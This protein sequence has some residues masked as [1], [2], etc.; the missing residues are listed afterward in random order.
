[1]RLHPWPRP[2]LECS[3]A[4]YFQPCKKQAKSE[5]LRSKSKTQERVPLTE[6]LTNCCQRTYLVLNLLVLFSAENGAYGRNHPRAFGATR[7]K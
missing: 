5:S 2:L 3:L 1:M 4:F 6:N 7:Q